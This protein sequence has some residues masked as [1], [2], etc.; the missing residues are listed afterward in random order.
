MAK[1][2]VFGRHFETAQYFTFKLVHDNS[3]AYTNLCLQLQSFKGSAY[4]IFELDLNIFVMT[5]CRPIPHF[6]FIKKS[7]DLNRLETNILT[8][9]KEAE[10]SHFIMV[11]GIA[12]IF[13]FKLDFVCTNLY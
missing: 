2:K 1:L 6:S 12:V 11:V 8:E 5:A 7:F 10:V 4:F 13:L 3:T 9:M